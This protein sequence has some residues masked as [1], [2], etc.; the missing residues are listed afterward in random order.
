MQKSKSTYVA[1]CMQLHAAVMKPY[2]MWNSHWVIHNTA[3]SQ[4]YN[5]L[6]KYYYNITLYDHTSEQKNV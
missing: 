1:D 2:T 5:I 4:K 6:Y 3:S